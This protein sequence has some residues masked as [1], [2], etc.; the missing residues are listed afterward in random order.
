MGKMKLQLQSVIFDLDGVICNTDEYH[1]RAWKQIADEIGVPFGR[2]DNDKLRGISRDESL[3]IL[4]ENYHGEKFSPKEKESLTEK[5]NAIYKA[6]L[7]GM[8]PCDLMPGIERTIG[9]LRSL[10]IKT[11]IGSSSKN[12]RQIVSR[13]GIRPFFDVI[14][15]GNDIRY[16]KPVPEVFLTAAKKLGISPARCLV[17]EDAESGVQAAH[18]AGMKVVCVGVAAKKKIGDYNI[19]NISELLEIVESLSFSSA[20]PS[21]ARNGG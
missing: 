5:K 15:D 20:S 11:A 1:F 2:K 12:A 6:Y 19:Y 18:V 9:F 10:G 7:S 16:S 14:V 4:L 17:V 13:L 8:T 21:I 3:D